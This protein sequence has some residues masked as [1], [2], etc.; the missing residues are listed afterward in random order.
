MGLFVVGIFLIALSLP[1]VHAQT[2]SGEKRTYFENITIDPEGHVCYTESIGK[3]PLNRIEYRI[4]GKTVLD[5]YYSFETYGTKI[6]VS[7]F[8]GDGSADLIYVE[9]E[10]EENRIEKVNFYRGK[11]FQ[12][13]L[14]RHLLHAL[15]TAS[16]PLIRE[17]PDEQM[18]ARQIQSSLAALEKHSVAGGETGFYTAERLF[19]PSNHK[20]IAYAFLASDTLARALRSIIE[21]DYKVLSQEPEMVAKYKLEISILL[22]IDPAMRP[23]GSGK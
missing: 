22:S 14:K 8:D 4:N 10:Y 13:H 23:T 5:V 9:R 16:H 19:E 3:N 12:E 6:E 21:G 20:D 15:R 17:R 2:G 11:Q 18:R 7:D 1:D